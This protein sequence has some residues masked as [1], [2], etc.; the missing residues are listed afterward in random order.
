MVAT[1]AGV[2]FSKLKAV[3]VEDNTASAAMIGVIMQ[4]L[5]IDALVDPSGRSVVS[6]ALKTKPD[7]IF[8]DLNLPGTSGF[9]IIK[10][11]RHWEQLDST[12][13]VAVSATDPH[14]GIPKCK[15]AGFD[16]FIAKPIT[17]RTLR[18]QIERLMT[19]HDVWDS[20]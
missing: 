20:R 13:I 6:M 5:G 19:G 2:D 4:R 7:I 15:A 9:E 12:L 16:G 14:T 1:Q 3:A 18:M 8:C 10:S 11:L 17:R